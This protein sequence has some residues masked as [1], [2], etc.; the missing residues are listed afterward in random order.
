MRM[1]EGFFEY[2]SKLNSLQIENWKT[3]LSLEVDVALL[4]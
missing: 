1:M 3:A 2:I 4:I